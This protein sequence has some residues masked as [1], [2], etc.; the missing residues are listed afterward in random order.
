MVIVGVSR[1][2]VGR[3]GWG[4]KTVLGGSHGVVR[5]VYVIYVYYISMCLFPYIFILFAYLCVL[6]YTR[7]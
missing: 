1:G 2:T 3:A 7:I 4:D 6:C 5:S